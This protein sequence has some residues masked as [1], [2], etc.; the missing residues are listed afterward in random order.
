ML[1]LG[2]GVR[3]SYGMEQVMKFKERVKKLWLQSYKDVL[4]VVAM[5]GIVTVL[6]C[7]FFDLWGADLS[8]PVNYTG[9]DDFSIYNTARIVQESGWNIGTDRLSALDEYYYNNN[10][11]ISG[12]HNAD[13]FFVKLFLL[14]GGNNIFVAA[15]LT[16]Y[17]IF[18]MASLVMYIVLR[19]LKVR[20][21]FAGAGALVYA[22]L[23]FVFMRGVEH[24]GLSSHYFVPLAVLMAIWIY[25]DEK[26]MAPRKGFFKYGRNIG[27]IVMSLLLATQG[28]GYWQVFGCFIIM[29]SGVSVCIK[30]KDKNVLIR[31]G[32]NICAICVGVIICCIPV[33]VSMASGGSMAASGRPRF[34]T[35]GE[36]YGLKIV[37]L[38]LPVNG[39]GIGFW[40]ECLNLYNEKMPL[41]N[42]NRSAYLGFVGII[43]FV[44][45][46]V[47][48]LTNKRDDTYLRK[49][50]TVLSDINI[51]SVLLATVGGIGSILYLAGFNI[52]R[53]YNRI[54]VYIACVCIVAACLCADALADR[55]KKA[56]ARAVY[57]ATVAAFMMFAL[58][59]QNPGYKIDYEGNKATVESDKAFVAQLENVMDEDDCVFQ[60]PYVA[61]PE[62]EA[63]EEMDALEHLTGFFYSDKLRWS[64]GAMPESDHDAWYESTA[65]LPAEE[66]YKAV[67]DKGF[68]G[69][70]INRT[71]YEESELVTLEKQLE[72]LTGAKP[73]IS[74][75]ERLS[76]FKIR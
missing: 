48:L 31:A 52:L 11:I 3:N 1:P 73:I 66:L 76:F 53:S 45:L 42:E 16:Y 25:E 41:V 6:L 34:G 32:L 23:A 17:A 74:K 15:N 55:F 75:D 39:H 26:F 71:G 72:Y 13:I 65:H 38:L 10:E 22:F 62:D 18:Y 46:C 56:W 67:L 57:V 29:V 19:M 28:I 61:F 8:V 12:L 9:H 4:S 68:D 69:I 37:Q 33:F 44:I 47:W 51:C 64:Y 50:L 58:W 5:W 54:S 40:Q 70:Y 7:G 21:C 30:N 63:C 27:G 49:R 35:E 36:S 20:R 24:I 14:V 43:G 2:G 59:E 60:L